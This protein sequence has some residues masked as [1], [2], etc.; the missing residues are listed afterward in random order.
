MAMQREMYNFS[1]GK[2][3]EHIRD[4]LVCHYTLTCRED[5]EY[6]RDVRYGT[7]ISDALK[8]KL[9]LART[10]LPDRQFQHIFDNSLVSHGLTGFAFGVGWPCILIGMNFLP[11]KHGIAQILGADSHE[12]QIVDNIRQAEQLFAHRKKK[13]N[14]L[15]NQLPS[16]YE[17]LKTN[18]YMGKE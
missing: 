8:E 5:T 16:H 9:M 11:Y 6:W 12:K 13:I 15:V 1:M 14:E 2:L 17:Y 10:V 3:F 18:I 4:F 7:K